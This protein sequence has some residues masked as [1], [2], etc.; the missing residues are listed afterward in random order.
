MWAVMMIGMMTPSVAPMI[1]IYA[2]VGRQAAVQDKP[3]ASSGWF[4]AGYL[5]AWTLFSLR[6]DRVCNGRLSAQPC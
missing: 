1:L 2:R 3:F 4:V 5:I 6:R